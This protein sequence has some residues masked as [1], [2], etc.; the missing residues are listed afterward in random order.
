MRNKNNI[1]IISIARNAFSVHGLTFWNIGKLKD[2]M[3]ASQI[4]VAVMIEPETRNCNA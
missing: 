4:P 1:Q 3:I 2:A